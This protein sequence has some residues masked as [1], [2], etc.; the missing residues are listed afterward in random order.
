M[1]GSKWLVYILSF[2]VPIFGFI[3]FW[4]NF[5]CHGEEINSTA[6]GALIAGFI[7]IVIWA[8]LAAI[9]ITYT[10]LGIGFNWTL[11]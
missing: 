6:R 2:F 11:P 5:A 4:I 8:I 10:W 7:G 1:K 9:G 3:T